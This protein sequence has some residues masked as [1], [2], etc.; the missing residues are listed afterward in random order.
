[1]AGRYR[2]EIVVRAIHSIWE[3]WSEMAR[4]FGGENDMQS[5]LADAIQDRLPAD[6]RCTRE[7]KLS[8][9][10]A[11]RLPRGCRPWSR[12][13]VSVYRGSEPVALLELDYGSTKPTVD[14]AL[15]NAE[16]K[17]MGNCDGIGKT[18]GRPFYSERGLGP[19]EIRFVQEALD[20]FPVRG[21]FFVN[22]R[23]IPE[24]D[25]EVPAIWHETKGTGFTGETHFWSAVMA[26]DKRTTL[27]Q[28][29]QRFAKQRVCCWFYSLCEEDRLAY[30][31]TRL[32]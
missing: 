15:H 16:L 22:P 25:L 24:L 4:P 23:R 19:R 1:M 14:H 26:P 9:P 7:G 5:V 2:D 30:L 32:D 10:F 31:P 20:G 11:C 27:R 29:L 13:D 17:L 28:V 21:L 18:T 3:E 8:L 12:Y 6:Y